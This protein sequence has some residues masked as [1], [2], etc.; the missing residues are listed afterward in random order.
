MYERYLEEKYGEKI[1]NE[2]NE[3]QNCKNYEK[4]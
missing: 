3:Q 1:D 4:K 2:N